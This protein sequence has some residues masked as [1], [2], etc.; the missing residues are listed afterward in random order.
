MRK[1]TREWIDAFSTP[2]GG[3]TKEQALALGI[4]WPLVKGWKSRV[5]GKIISSEAAA[6]FEKVRTADLFWGT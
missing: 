3:W 6:E 2:K 1:V 5:E 4:E